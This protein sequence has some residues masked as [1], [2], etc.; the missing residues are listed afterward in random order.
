[1]PSKQ[2]HRGQHQEDPNLFS[3][4]M[5]PKLNEAVKDLS[6]LLSRG[7][8]DNAS[9]K[10]VGDHFRLTQR[11]R[12]ALMR[13]SC[14]F[15]KLEH[16]KNLSLGVEEL[17]GRSMAIDGYNLLITVEAALAGGIVI[18]C[19]DG[20]YRDIASVH[21]TYR[22]VEETIPALEMIG[23]ILQDLGIASVNWYLDKPV[24]NSGKLKGMMYE[25]GGKHGFPWK[26]RLSNN[27]DKVFPTL[28]DEVIVSSDS[29]ILDHIDTNFNLHKFIVDTIP[30]VNLIALNGA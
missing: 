19:Q 3:A 7:Y 2:K 29:W 6:F 27:P 16:R 26:V 15:D 10:L 8:S 14:G 25:I 17:P 18:D 20:Y 23:R 21:G 24:S 11:Q 13:A 28:V 22:R 4:K 12:Q 1:M 9:I 30:N 5:L